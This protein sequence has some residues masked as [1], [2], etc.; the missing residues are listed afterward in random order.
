MAKLMHQL[1]EQNLWLCMYR[2]IYIYLSYN[3]YIF[4]IIYLYIYI[5]HTY[6]KFMSNKVGSCYILFG[7]GCNVVGRD[8][9]NYRQESY[10]SDNDGNL[11]NKTGCATKSLH[12]DSWD[13]NAYRGVPD[14]CQAAHAKNRKKMMPVETEGILCQH[15][16]TNNNIY[17][18]RHILFCCKH[19]NAKQFTHIKYKIQ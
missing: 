8:A 1:H 17:W 6:S 12:I 13:I 10:T 4:I 15:T 16:P 14:T 9:E 3:I 19:K 7:Q 5:I 2:Y 11:N 18:T